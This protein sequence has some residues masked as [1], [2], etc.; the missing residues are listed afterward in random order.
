MESF[1]EQIKLHDLEDEVSLS[2]SGC[3]GLCSI[4]PVVV[5]YPEDIFYCQVEPE[6]VPEIV[7]KTLIRGKL[8]DR[9]LFKDPITDETIPHYHQIPFYMNQTRILLRN[10]G[11]I[12]PERIEEYIAKRVTAGFTRRSIKCLRN[13]S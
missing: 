2:F 5:I 10:C 4:G 7:E 9:L 1:R 12:N 13:M 11:L 6:D 8:V 3:H